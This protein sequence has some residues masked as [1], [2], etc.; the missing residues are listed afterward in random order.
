MAYRQAVDGGGTG[1]PRRGSA[2]PRRDDGGKPSA[3]GGGKLV[4]GGADR[5]GE[6]VSA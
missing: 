2:D 3:V 4:R 1:D 6:G 5:D